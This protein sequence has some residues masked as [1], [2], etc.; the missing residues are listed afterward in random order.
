MRFI[1][2]TAT[3]LFISLNSISKDNKEPVNRILFIFDASQSMLGKWQSGRKIDI[4]KRLLINMVDSLKDV[5]N[6]ELGLRVYG[7]KSHY[8]PQD[9]DD[10]YLE[11]NFLNSFNAADI[12]KKELA[13]VKSRGTTPIARSLEEGAKDFPDDKGRNIVILITDGKEECG[14]DPCAVSHLYQRNGIILKPFVIG[15]GLD[16]EWKKSFDCVGRFFDASK[17]QDFTN[18]LN[19]VIS[20]V[21]DN[22]TAQV[23]LLDHN[24]EPTETNVN[25]T[26]YN[27]F[28]GIPKYN[29]IHTINTS[30]NPDTMIIDPVLTYKVVA[31]TIPT[32]SIKG[33]IIIPGKHTIIPL[34]VPQGSL[35]IKMNSKIT[36]QYIIRPKDMDT[37]LNVQEINKKEKYL[38]GKYD[39]ELLSLPRKKF[40]NVEIYPGKETI[41]TIPTPGLANIVLPSKGYGGVYEKDGDKLNQIYRF[42]AKNTNHRLTLIPG[43]YKIIFKAISAKKYLYT[44]EKEFKIKSGKS[45]LIKIY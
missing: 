3:L 33:V 24:G 7:H 12:I 40:N 32:V 25:I 41:Y 4:A 36:Y 11:V 26:F 30:G 5:K 27:D 45:E 37:I 18:I 10:S 17:E 35:Q 19:I 39:I 23:N 15:V 9:C 8:P 16:Q 1:L 20:H 13:V 31:H 2:I 29:Y 14:M 6:L 38:A 42:N 44:I 28:T 43:R 34:K 21:I 22:T